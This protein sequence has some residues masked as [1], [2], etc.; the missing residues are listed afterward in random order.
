MTQIFWSKQKNQNRWN[1]ITKWNKTWT[2]EYFLL[3]ISEKVNNPIEIKAEPH[4]TTLDSPSQIT[5]KFGLWT[6]ETENCLKH[7]LYIL[8]NGAICVLMRCSIVRDGKNAS[9][10]QISTAQPYTPNGKFHVV[11][12]AVDPK[13]GKL[14]RI[15][16]RN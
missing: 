16:S 7:L 5:F 13:N 1:A 10:W 8:L 14:L 12:A 3:N 9:H 11:V 4:E 6:H 15:E 2:N